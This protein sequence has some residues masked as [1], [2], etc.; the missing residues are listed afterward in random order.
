LSTEDLLRLA[1]VGAGERIAP[2]SLHGEECDGVSTKEPWLTKR[3]MDGQGWEEELPMIERAGRVMM[4]WAGL[5]EEERVG[6]VQ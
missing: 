1:E 5:L 3:V 4:D 2:C 6:C